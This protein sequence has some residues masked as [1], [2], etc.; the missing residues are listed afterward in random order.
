MGNILVIDLGTSYFKVALFG[1]DGQLHDVVRLAVPVTGQDKGLAEL[2]AKTFEGL[3]TTGIQT[4]S[5]RSPQLIAGVDAVTFATQT[6]SFLLLDEHNQPMTP[7]ILWPDRRAL[8]C[9]NQAR[10]LFDAQENATLTGVPQISHQFM[11]AKLL[12]LRQY[13]QE[14]WQAAHLLL[15]SDYLTWLFTGR[16]MTEAGT[17]GLTGLIDIHQC[18]WLPVMVAR[19]GI[20]SEWLAS[21]VRAGTDLG[22]ISVVAA[23]RWSLP[24]SCRFIVGCLDQYAGAIGA[25]NAEPGR[26][27]ET[28][29]TV[30]ATVRC[31]DELSTTLPP[32]VFQ[33]PAF[34]P[35]RYFQMI[36]GN[37]SAN[38]LEWFRNQQP[39]RPSFE[40][41]VMEA[42]LVPPGAGGLRLRLGSELTVP[43]EVF[44]GLTQQHTRHHM[45]RCILEAVASALRDQVQTLCRPNMPE[46]IRSV[47]GASRSSLWLQI[48][49][50]V[51]GTS[52]RAIDCPEPTSMGAAILAEASL[53]GT[54]VSEI[55]RQWVQPAPAHLPDH[56]HHRQYQELGL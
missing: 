56:Q 29:G 34:V 12:W 14:L 13:R 48:K 8:E 24:E 54:E 15:I 22:P 49:A 52:V 27:S 51:L 20:K 40:Q 17:A 41:L 5:D 44:D 37:T 28:T 2:D 50:D 23:R 26:V 47:G 43:A 36:F 3:V 10:K 39:D 35:G 32:T 45:V 7:L 18:E 4:L 42:E 19:F 55:V 53:R 30:L 25:G 21:I 46:E 11:V 31:S 38:Y 1:R 9:E 16:F 6:N 33:G